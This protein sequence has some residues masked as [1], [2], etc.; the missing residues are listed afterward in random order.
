[1]PRRTRI[2]TATLGC[3]TLGV[4]SVGG[5]HL[6]FS[7]RC[8]WLGEVLWAPL[9]VVAAGIAVRV[10]VHTR[11]ARWLAV[12]ALLVFVGVDTTLNLDSR[13]GIW[14]LNHPARPI[15]RL[16][17][18]VPGL[19]L[20]TWPELV[21]E[22]ALLLIALPVGLAVLWD[23]RNDLAA[24]AALVAGG[25]LSVLLLIVLMA[26]SGGAGHIPFGLGGRAFV[27]FLKD[28]TEF[29]IGVALCLGFGLH[30]VHLRGERQ[31]TRDGLDGL[32]KRGRPTR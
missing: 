26:G 4:G 30:L 19:H 32:G 23:M 18:A 7:G 29:L 16:D 22:A 9:L 1:M 31:A 8:P 3:A 11:R 21:L 10:F 25:L 17:A 12:A 13:F 20:F 24:T 14:L 15:H 2:T 28:A 5:M 6:I 27:A